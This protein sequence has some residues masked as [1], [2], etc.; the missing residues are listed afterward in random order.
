MGGLVAYGAYIPHYRLTQSARSAVLGKGGGSRARSVA[1]YDEDATTMG[2]EAARTTLRDL[3]PPVAPERIYLAT[4]NPPYLDKTNAALLHAALGLS[5]STLAVDVGGA[6]RSAVAAILAAAEA[7]EPALAVLSDLR[8]GLAGGSEEMDSGDAAAAL[9]FGEGTSEAPVIAEL[10]ATGWTTEEFL[11]RWRVPGDPTS[12]VWEERFGESLYAPAA[13]ESFAEALKRANVSADQVDHLI[14][15]GL[16]GRAVK[17]FAA[18]SGVRR[19]AV[20]P[21]RA[22]VIG[23]SGTAQPGV[24]LADVLDRAGPGQTIAVVLLA[25][26]ASTLVLRTTE[27]LRTARR[28][29]PSVAEQVQAGDPGLSYATYLSWRGLLPTEPPRRPEPDAPAA[30]PTHRS[31]GFKYGFIGVR[32]DNCNTVQLPPNRVCFKCGAVDRMTP[33]PMA[34]VPAKVA[35]YTIDRLAYTPSPPMIAVV[36]DFE[37]GGRFRCELTDA[38]PDALAIGDPVELTFRRLFTSGGV[39]NYFWKARPVHATRAT[40]GTSGNEEV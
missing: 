14:V 6:P 7:P 3:P 29:R 22:S 28:A 30:P 5:R 8:V 16:A 38:D 20:A 24:L 23:N 31:S 9:L 13:A 36:L 40:T 27:G 34:D 1:A 2:V 26:G 10:L 32:C 11:D 18:S 39:H 12:R 21:D 37:G 33:K 15:C 25:D 19:E 4:A 17:R 35:T